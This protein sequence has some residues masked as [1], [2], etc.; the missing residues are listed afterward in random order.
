MK[1]NWLKTV[2]AINNKRYTIPDGWETKEQV[3][4]S[5]QCAPDK[6]ADM[7]KPGISSG[8]IERSEFSVWN[9]KRRMT[10]KVTCYRIA[11]AGDGKVVPTKSLSPVTSST[12]EVKLLAA[13]KKAPKKTDAQV[14]KNYR[15]ATVEMVRKLR[16]RS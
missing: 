7:L 4:V 10:S 9:D 11:V 12:L 15:G 14:A 1:N 3:A 5:L 13:M 6:V 16:L 8:D 2:N